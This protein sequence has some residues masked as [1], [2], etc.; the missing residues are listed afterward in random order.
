VQ[1]VHGGFRL[2]WCGYRSLSPCGGVAQPQNQEPKGR[3]L[4]AP[5]IEALA[6]P[7]RRNTKSRARWARA[8]GRSPTLKFARFLSRP[9]AEATQIQ[10][11]F[12]WSVHLSC[13][14]VR[15]LARPAK[16]DKTDCPLLGAFQVHPGSLKRG[17]PVDL[18]K[19]DWRLWL[20]PSFLRQAD[21]EKCWPS[22]KGNW[23]QPKA[24][25]PVV[26]CR[27]RSTP[28]IALSGAFL[29]LTASDCNGWHRLG[30]TA[31]LEDP[32]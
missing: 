14:V 4:N 18:A 13:A 32:G 27:F 9:A 1:S 24:T 3:E 15:R 20:Q 2:P 28:R 31:R 5:S 11:G 22:G 12:V 8:F 30:T 25:L 17:Q 21:R 10:F 16:L 23:N 29:P 6:R 26:V 7:S 19:R